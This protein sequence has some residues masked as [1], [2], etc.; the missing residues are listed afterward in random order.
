MNDRTVAEGSA[1]KR[2][3]LGCCTLDL[4]AGE[5][6]DEHGE[7]AGLRRQGLE[8]LLVLGRRAGQVVSKDELMHQVWPRVVVGEGSLT[9]AIADVRRVLGDDE[10]RIVRTVAR[11]GYML[12]PE[13]SA[14]ESETSA[15]N[16]VVGI[17]AEGVVDAGANA[18]AM[19]VSL[20]E[21]G[22]PRAAEAGVTAVTAPAAATAAAAA[23]KVVAALAHS[24]AASPEA[25][26]PL[27]SAHEPR[28]RAAWLGALALAVL[29]A[30]AG[31][32]ALRG[33]AP[34]WLSPADLA[35]APLP[36]EVPPLSIIVLP[37][38]VDNEAAGNEWLADSLHGDLV[39]IVAR[40]HNSLVIARET[41]ATYKGKAV[42]PRQV[43][44]EMGVRH[45]VRGSLRQ[46]GA[47][48][49]LNLTLIDGESGV[50]RWAETFVIERAQLAQAVGDF[51]VALER[52]LTPALYRTTVERR[53]ALSSTE[54][55]ADDLAMQGYAMWYRGVSR[56]NVLAAREL[57]ERALVLDPNSPRA[58]AGIQFTTIN[59]LLNGWTDDRAA[60]ARRHDDAVMNLERVDRDGSPTYSAK[61]AHL[62]QR[63][64]FRAMLRQATEWA[65]R[66]RLPLAFG[67]H[68]A[69]LML[70]GRFDE[71]IPVMER[72]L[73]LGPR[74]PFRAEWQYRLAVAHYGAGHHELAREWSQSAA[75]TN[76]RL[77][78]PP[79]HAAALMQ[80]GR[81]EAA[82]QAFDEHMKRHPK[83]TTAQ[84]LS[85]LPSDEPGYVEMR[86]RLMASLREL[87]LRD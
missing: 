27:A 65:E 10:H 52:T 46:E 87:G 14:P 76:A 71:A 29:L 86:A 77:V 30:A 7:L 82:Q 33:G 2:L 1:A 83:F 11:R 60:T 35:R 42:D 6:F 25:L 44:R 75:N 15:G 16:P 64:D 24:A 61:V 57:F 69:A 55:T 12:V 73:R 37:L 13:R 47:T 49:Q 8:L 19:V 66:Y 23:P 39:T 58:W 4:L 34:V 3:P 36:R 32:M 68:G 81:R 26:P 59:Q 67:A 18:E 31:W 45:V 78:W 20:P 9:Q 74:D 84:A 40:L 62:Y 28:R 17:G 72:G 79:I 54:V 63:R 48:I 5:L 22:D 56:E 21:R 70:N 43:A 41:A 51:A 50:Q 53:A 38:S 80:L 85:R